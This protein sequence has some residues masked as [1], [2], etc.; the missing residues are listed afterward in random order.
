MADHHHSTP[1]DAD[2]AA[3]SQA[4]RFWASFTKFST[5]SVLACVAILILLAL[6]VA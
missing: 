4:E 3:I 6:F 5:W 1:A 2:P